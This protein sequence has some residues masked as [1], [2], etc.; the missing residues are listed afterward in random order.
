MVRG[1]MYSNPM[2][3]IFSSAPNQ[4]IHGFKHGVMIMGTSAPKKRQ[5]RRRSQQTWDA[6]WGSPFPKRAEIWVEA[7]MERKKPTAR[8]IP[9][10]TLY[11]E[12]AVMPSS[13]IALDTQMVVMTP[14]SAFVIWE[15]IGPIASTRTVFK[16]GRPPS[17]KS[18]AVLFG[19]S[20][21]GLSGSSSFSVLSSLIRTLGI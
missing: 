16:G 11:D 20:A 4:R 8:P 10:K 5:D 2:S 17:R 7:A 13:P 18:S 1:S 9:S 3:M 19:G 6:S 12:T 14:K 21:S 15:R